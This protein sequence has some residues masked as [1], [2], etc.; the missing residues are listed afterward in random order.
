MTTYRIPVKQINLCT[1]GELPIYRLNQIAEEHLLK[2]AKAHVK[3]EYKAAKV[4][5]VAGFNVVHDNINRFTKLFE[6]RVSMLNDYQK[7][8]AYHN[9]RKALRG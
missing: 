6:E 3:A 2:I 7:F 5:K 8:I 4:A 1:F 9:E